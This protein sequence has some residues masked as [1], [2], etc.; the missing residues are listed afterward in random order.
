MTGLC[1]KVFI[2][3]DICIATVTVAVFYVNMVLILCTLNVLNDYED[4]LAKFLSGATHGWNAHA[5]HCIGIGR[6][7]V[8]KLNNEIVTQSL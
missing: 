6:K 8:P 5:I 1:S 7:V 3:F 2:I 4:G